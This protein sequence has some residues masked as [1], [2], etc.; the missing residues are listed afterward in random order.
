MTGCG[1]AVVA[2]GANTCRVEVRSVNNRFF[3]LSFR[4]REGFGILEPRAEEL[5]RRRVRRGAVQVN[6]DVAGPVAPAA[7]RLDHGQLAAYLDDLEAICAARDLPTP[8]SVDALLGL[9]GTLVDAPPDGA[10][11]ERAWPLVARA[12]EA[13]LDRLDLMRRAE[14][15]ALA[16][17]LRGLL[18][19]VT[20]LVAAIRV[21]VPAVLAEHRG[22]LVER[23]GKLLEQNGTSLSEADIAHEV[24]LVADR[25]DIA[26]E[27]VRLES[28]VAQFDRLLGEP[29]PGRSLDF[30]TQEL[31]REANT[32]GS[33]S[34]DVE[35]AH[36]V[37]ELKTRIERLREQVQ[38]VE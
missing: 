13:A 37:V 26:E 11:V 29:S 8:R 36:T 9:P 18:G 19:E 12:L 17:A 30:L 5:I 15:A 16:A 20:T 32:I 25:S 34:L 24:A 31:A 23:V 2:D 35:M 4:A 1:E 14:G 27:L 10:A 33:K 6:L 28:H 7:R 3:K 22:R 21:R 38:N